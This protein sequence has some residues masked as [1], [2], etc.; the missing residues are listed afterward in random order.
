MGLL[1]CIKTPVLAKGF[2]NRGFY[3]LWGLIVLVFSMLNSPSC[4]AN[5]LS[6]TKVSASSPPMNYRLAVLAYRDKPSTHKRWHP[7]VSYLNQKFFPVSFQLEVLHLGELEAAVRLHQVDFVL[8][9]P[10]HYVLLTYQFGLTS[11]L[12]SLINL[13]GEFATDR[14]GGVIFTRHDRDDLVTLEDIK[15]Q[16]IAAAATSSLG[17]YQMQAF[18]L[19][20]HGVR[21]PGHDT[22][23][24]TGQP[25]SLALEAVLSGR[26]DVGFVRTGVLEGLAKKGKLDMSQLK[27][28]NAQRLPDFPFVTSTAL[29]PEW[30]FAAMP[31]VDKEVA[32]QVAAA[33]LTIPS[34]SDLARS[35]N[36]AGF[37]IAGDYRTIDALMRELRLAPF[38][39]E[40]FTLRDFVDMWFTE[41]L[42]GLGVFIF[43]VMATLLFMVQRQR[44]LSQERNRLEVALNQVR[45]LS[46][47]V[48]Q[49]PEAIVI[50]DSEGHISYMNPMFMDM[51]GYAETEMLGKNPRVLQSGLTPIEQYQVMWA[52]L[53][54][55]KVWRGE[56]S[57]RRK[58]GTI[59]PAQAIIS[60]VKNAL[61]K[62]TH[63]LGIQ[64]DL[65]ERKRREK[66]IEE[67]LYQ[68]EVTKLANRN[69]LIETLDQCLQANNADPIKGCLVL[70]NIT[71][72]KF[73]NQLHG[74]ETGDGVLCAVA[75]RLMIVYGSRGMVARLAA[76]HFAVFCENN[77]LEKSKVDAWIEQM[78]ELA[79]TAL[80]PRLEVGRKRFVLEACFGVSAFKH[81]EGQL[82]IDAI[83]QVFNQA[84]MAL[85]AA[86]QPNAT[87]LQIYNAQMMAD[88][89]EKHQ[90]QLDLAHAIKDQQLRLFVQPQV[91]QSQTLVGLECLVRWQ[92]PEK[93][94][95]PPGH[96]IGLAEESDLIVSLGE[97][98]LE[99]ACAILAQVQK[100]QPNIRVAVNI[101]PKHFRQAY[102]NAQC[103]G[104]LAAAGANPEGLMIEITESLFVD[105][106]N[107][108]IAKMT[109]LKK[110]GIRFSIDDFGT[111]YSSLSYLQHLPVD[112]LKIDRAFILGME[113]YGLEGSL[114]SS[115]YAMAQQMQLEVVAE[116]IENTA[117]WQQ[118][119]DFD[120]LQLQG[121]LFAKPQF[122][123]DWLKTWQGAVNV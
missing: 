85:R 97:W 32:R 43:W 117:Q 18:E 45:L 93:G 29:Y 12:A 94:L 71:R 20:K 109:E 63:Y 116:G 54:E 21:L 113:H 36:I 14:F 122:Y 89:L 53:K 1:S 47:A 64:R 31:Q 58:D 80:E 120:Q 42:I 106:L 99:Q 118:L 13:E 76:D 87:R 5:D 79:F 111:G 70:I 65:T 19:L 67:L 100:T 121:Y 90:L 22:L 38:D 108:V 35:M 2:N 48:D 30:P 56:L 49:S 119:A 91:S 75:Q 88:Q 84:G 72:F 77:K 102:F 78:G 103:L 50:T 4:F 24:E 68:D 10:A 81:A 101:S 28:I 104:F 37:N 51:T 44:L 39:K 23:I 34:M 92:H 46:Q 33:L 107:E 73:I 52:I 7:L 110:H 16:R 40:T 123:P 25:Q 74:M 114:V 69:K 115:I 57:N 95:L 9:Q 8:T 86:R 3:P 112:E 6:P 11:P 61:G 59:Y 17:A 96:F 41:L 26:A 66:R 15:G 62:V 98:V 60:P 83:N 55:G 105:D 27:L 82:P